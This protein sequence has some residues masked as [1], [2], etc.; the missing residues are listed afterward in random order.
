MDLRNFREQIDTI[1]SEILRLFSE[2]MDVCRQIAIFKKEQ[3]LATR[4]LTREQEKLSS[5]EEKAGVEIASYA[6]RLFE[7]LLE[8]SRD[9][10]TGKK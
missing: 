5:I 8:L 1:D 7:A 3:G 2:R 6:R 10:Q 4:D 9:Y